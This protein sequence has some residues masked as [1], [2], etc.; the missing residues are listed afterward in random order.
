MTFTD[1]QIKIL[2]AAEELIAEK[3]FEETTVRNICQK[4]NINVAMISYYFG[5]KEKM[6]TYLYQYRVQRAKETFAE[7]AHTIKE[8]TPQMQVKE[9]IKFI[10]GQMFKY[11]Y[12]HGFVKQEFRNTE[13]MDEELQDFYTIVVEKLNQI[14]KQGISTGVFLYAPNAEDLLTILIGSVLFVIRNKRFYEQ[15]I[16]QATEENF[17]SEAEI[18]I[19]Q[20]LYQTIFLQLGYKQ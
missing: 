17:L 12:F 9:V 8:G 3:G 20:S 6:L 11:K 19:R 7:F 1:K 10:I 18:K 15:Y 4:A 16:P 2:E 13:L 14:I 5:S